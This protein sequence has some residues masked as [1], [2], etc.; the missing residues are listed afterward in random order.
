MAFAAILLTGLIG[1]AF[2]MTLVVLGFLD[3]AVRAWDAAS[4]SDRAAQRL[5]S[6]GPSPDRFSMGF[7]AGAGRWA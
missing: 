2:A 3:V 1:V 6:G 5:K 4:R 7:T